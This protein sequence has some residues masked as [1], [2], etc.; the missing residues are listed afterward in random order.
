MSKTRTAIEL[1]SRQAGD[2][3]KCS[4]SALL[5]EGDETRASEDSPS[6]QIVHEMTYRKLLRVTCIGC[7]GQAVLKRRR[8]VGRR[9][10]GST[11]TRARPAEIACAGA[12][13]GA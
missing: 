9:S 7:Q 13:E 12:R 11:S 4:L 3:S 1:V 2:S 8:G 5:S 6:S 10:C